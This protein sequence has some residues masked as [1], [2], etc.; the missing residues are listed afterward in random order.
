MRHLFLII[1]TSKTGYTGYTG[2]R[3]QTRQTHANGKYNA[4]DC[5]NWKIQ[6]QISRSPRGL[7]RVTGYRGRKSKLK[8]EK[9]N[10]APPKWTSWDELLTKLEFD[11]G[12]PKIDA[13]VV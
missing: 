2:W 4:R 9:T 6:H 7:N 1:S 5:R 10:I 8:F 3:Q 11:F 13:K 12:I